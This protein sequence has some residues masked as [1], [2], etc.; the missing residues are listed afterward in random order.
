[1]IPQLPLMSY[2]H[3][4]YICSQFKNEAGEAMFEY[5][6]GGSTMLFS[7]YVDLYRS[8]EHDSDWYRLMT[9]QVPRNV[10]IFLKEHLGKPIH[11]FGPG[12]VERQQ[13]YINAIHMDNMFY[14]YIL[15]D[16]RC[17]VECANQAVSHMH[18]NS[19][20]YVHDYER[21]KYHPIEKF[22]KLKEKRIHSGD[23]RVLACF[24]LK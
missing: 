23:H 7:R 2:E 20:L 17:R 21:V 3:I 8:V 14:D 15:I 16:G 24:S 9:A 19:L 18:E 4:S 10:Q 1:M 12:D 22:L 13:E 6:C 11:P 5:G